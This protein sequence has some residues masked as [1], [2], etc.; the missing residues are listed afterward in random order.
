MSMVCGG[1]GSVW[2][3]EHLQLKTQVVVKFITS[4]RRGNDEALQRFR[5]EAALSAQAKGP[6]VV[7]IF[8]H[9]ESLQGLPYIAMELLEGEDLGK[10]IARDGPVEPKLFCDWLSQA[11]RGLARAHAKGIVHRDIKPENTWPPLASAPYPSWR[12][13]RRK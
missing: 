1:M 3:A 2:V 13:R 9:G 12:P 11:C 8:D 4:E 10:R 6:H 7:Q 5:R